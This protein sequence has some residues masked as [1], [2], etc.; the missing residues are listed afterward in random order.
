T[1]PQQNVI[2]SVVLKVVVG[3]LPSP[4]YQLFVYGAA[5]GIVGSIIVVG[6]LA[7]RRRKKI[8]RRSPRRRRR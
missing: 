1:L 2:Y 8:G 4:Y 3:T 5:I 7:M 6:A